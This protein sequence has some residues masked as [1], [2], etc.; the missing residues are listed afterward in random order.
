VSFAID[1]RFLLEGGPHQTDFGTKLLVLILK[2]DS[3]NLE[4]LRQGF[5]NAVAAVEHYQATGEFLELEY[6]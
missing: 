3:H 2:A 1:M 4:L 5:P 6:D